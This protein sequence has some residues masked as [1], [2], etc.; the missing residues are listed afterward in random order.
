MK[1]R[2]TILYGKMIFAVIL[3][4]A[5]TACEEPSGGGGGTGSTLTINGLA[6]Y[7]GKYVFALDDNDLD[8]FA[9]ASV[10]GNET[11]GTVTGGLVKSGSVSLKVFNDDNTPYTGS[12]SNVLFNIISNNTA[13]VSSE[14]LIMLVMTA[15]SSNNGS[16]TGTAVNPGGGNNNGGGNT[17]AAITSFSFSL[18]QGYYTINS[19]NRTINVIV[20]PGTDIT[21]LTPVINHSGVTINPAQGEPVDF[22]EPVVFTVSA[23]SGAQ[24]SYTV[25]VTD[26]ITTT[27]LLNSY[28]Q[29]Y[30]SNNINTPVPVKVS[31]NLASNGLSSLLNVLYSRNSYVAL[32]L[33]GSTGMT[34]FNLGTSSTGKNRIVSF[35]LPVTATG[36]TNGDSLSP[37]FQYFTSLKSITGVNVT[38]LGAFSF[39]ERSSLETSNFPA[40]TTVGNYAFSRCTGLTSITIGNIV[41]SIGSGAFRDCTGLTSITFSGTIASSGFPAYSYTD[42]FPGDLRSKYLAAGGGPGTYTRTSG[43][44]TWTKVN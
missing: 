7:N 24:T 31:I 21:A 17:I 22:T 36:I 42:S 11:S 19:A 25:T 12:D 3:A 8:L 15:V 27:A 38:T 13:T 23:E 16:A 29:T 33:S 14:N 30:P 6:D 5:F 35:V 18:S 41:T 43:S 1:T 9:A 44:N 26:T 32:D 40:L 10:T 39:H 34:T 20:P 2:Q 4:L 37:T 28:L